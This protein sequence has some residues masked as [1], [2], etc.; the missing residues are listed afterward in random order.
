MNYI[1]NF[2]GVRSDVQALDMGVGDNAER[3][4]R[5]MP[6]CLHPFISGTNRADVSCIREIKAENPPIF[7]SVSMRSGIPATI[8]LLKDRGR[9]DGFIRK[10]RRKASG[11]LKGKQINIMISSFVNIN[12]QLCRNLL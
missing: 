7:K 12:E 11:Q 6:A 2:E 10:C 8:L 3:K 1:E 4:N 5:D 9:P